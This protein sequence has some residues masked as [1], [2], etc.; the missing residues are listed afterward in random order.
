VE[1]ATGTV[2]ARAEQ[3]DGVLL[4]A[5]REGVTYD[6]VGP[7][8]VAMRRELAARAKADL[9]VQAKHEQAR[10][11]T[12]ATE[13]LEKALRDLGPELNQAVN[14]ATAEALKKKAAQLGRVKEIHDDVE[15]GTLTITVEV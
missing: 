14:R 3:S 8:E 9:E 13:R 12:E 10:V 6:D 11:Q 15:R 1:P 2:S 7:A 4:Q 5:Q